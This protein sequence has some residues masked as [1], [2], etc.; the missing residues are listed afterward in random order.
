MDTKQLI[1]IVITAIVASFMKELFSWFIP[2]IKKHS[3]KIAVN[4]KVKRIFSVQIPFLLLDIFLLLFSYFTLLSNIRSSEPV[5]HASVFMILFWSWMCITML[6]ESR[7][8]IDWYL[9]HLKETKPTPL[10][11]GTSTATNSNK[12]VK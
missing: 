12:N 9:K 6:R 3:I 4:P 10:N 5:T 8:D 11:I 7:K 1:T 2:F